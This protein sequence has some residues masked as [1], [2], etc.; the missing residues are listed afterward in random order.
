M[1]NR[2]TWGFSGSIAFAC[3]A[4]RFETWPIREV[5]KI[6]LTAANKVPARVLIFSKLAHLKKS[7][8]VENAM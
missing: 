8:N 4:C 7:M 6:L 3:P 5:L 1:M 2:F